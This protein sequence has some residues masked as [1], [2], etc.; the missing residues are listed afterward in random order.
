MQKVSVQLEN[1]YGIG[2]LVYEFDFSQANAY[3]VYAP[4]GFMK[5]SLSKT[6][7]DLSR[8]KKPSDLIHPERETKWAIKDET[9]SDLKPE[10]IFVIEPYNE[11][12][13]S[14]KTSLLLVNQTIKKQYDE[15]LKNIEDKKSELF[16]RLKQRSG[17]TGRTVTPEAE[18]LKHFGHTSIYDLL[19]SL[20]ANGSAKPNERLS[21]IVYER[22]FNDKALAL[23]ESGQIS[24]QL[25]DYIEKYNELIEGSPILSKT[26]NHYHA[27]SIN[28]NLTD[29][30]FFAASHSV[31]LFNGKTK[32]EI[33]SSADLDTKIEGEKT[34]I[35]ADKDLSSKFDAIDKKL[36]TKELREFRD[37]LLVNKDIVA[38]L[39]NFKKLQNDIWLAYLSAEH[40]SYLDFLK[41]YRVGKEIIKQ[42]IEAARQ[43]KT[44]WEEVVKIFNE[45]FTV[46]FTLGVTNQ[47]DVILKGTK[48][49]ISFGFKDDAQ[50]KLVDK[51]LLLEVLSQGE[52]R[53]LYILNIL[54]EINARR[55]QG[56]ET[57]VIVDDIAD[58]FDYKN[59]YAIVEYLK[60]VSRLDRFFCIILTHNFDFYRTI[61]SRLNIY[62]ERRLFV[63]KN[64][65]DIFLK[66]EIY[67]ENP[68]DYWKDHLNESR[69]AISS[70][71]FIRNLA[72]YCGKK[73]KFLKL[74]SLLHLK[75]D[76]LVF[77]MQE[78]EDIFKDIIIK[79]NLTLPDPQRPVVDVIFELA[80]TIVQEN[81][82]QAELESKIILSIAI[83]L[84]AE[85]FMINKIADQQFVN[86]I[87]K[88]QTLKLLERF[89][90]QF[91]NEKEKVALMEQVNLMT[92]ENIHLNS[93]M[94]EPILDMSPKHLKQLYTAVK[95]VN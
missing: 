70:I 44:E 62:K 84:K 52:K 86:G 12:F 21:T 69:F 83:R 20:E 16:K 95:V 26:F 64:G 73:D 3:S 66:P 88:N 89:R 31:N 22:L 67:K 72:D 59:K 36:T 11:S 14:E 32:E 75:T 78:L 81:D 4:N 1:C 90:N 82:E 8:D 25:K 47:E 43:E 65:R 9:G 54:F 17:L 45:R 94:Y 37:Y 27:K 56:Q 74:T 35:F 6:F 28:K 39:G 34:R 51:K 13:D 92:P 57:L 63:F 68:F 53:A 46:P 2:K 71:P 87:T 10:Q 7:L 58:S 76:T 49:E 29:N 55:K 80:D 79:P 60:D 30:G 41:E 33:A 93:F 23:L 5:T 91:T 42:S 85:S 48:P 19:D 50:P 24:Q 18:L 61:S 15:A 40:E 77:T 38:D